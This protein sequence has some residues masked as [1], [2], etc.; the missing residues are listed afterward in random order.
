MKKQLFGLKLILTSV[1]CLFCISCTKKAPDTSLISTNEVET[2]QLSTF[3]YSDTCI[4][5]GISKNED[6]FTFQNL[7]TGLRYTL[8]YDNLTFFSDRH[9]GAITSSQVSIGQ[10][11]NITFYRE[12]KRLK[13]LEVSPNYFSYSNVSG[14]KFYNSSTRMEYL[15]DKYE[16]DDNL[17]VCSGRENISVL[18]IADNDILTICGNDHVIYSI[19]VDRG[20]GYV[21]LENDKYFID[22]FIEIDKDIRKI[23]EDMML[24]VPEGRYSVTISKD[25]TSAV[26]DITVG[27]NQEA[28]IDLSD[29]EIKKNFGNIY[30]TTNP[31]NATLIIDGEKVNDISKPVV[32]EYGIHEVIVR[33]DGY[34]A[35]SKYLSV[36][37]PSAEIKFTLDKLED[38]SDTEKEEKKND[39]NG[40]KSNVENKDEN[41]EENKENTAGTKVYIDAP[42]GAEVYLDGNYIGVAPTSFPKKIGVIVITLKKE[43][44]Q[45]RSYTIYLEDINSDS[46]YSF[47]DLLKLE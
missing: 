6:S 44:Y 29:V 20:H 40:S 39:D 12:A 32:M 26:K 38:D 47:S 21:S 25:G 17:V 4:I 24:T 45:P 23:T 1:L 43:G 19:I 7:E 18:E 27:R 31:E 2:T 41:K 46:R 30:F 10:I 11:C 15:G 5:T 8:S 37:S 22:G 34:K 16:L 35:L 13:T 14:F 3:I 42:S 36:G 33:A 9:S 28:V